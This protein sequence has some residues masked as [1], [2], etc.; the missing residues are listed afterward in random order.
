LIKP[1]DRVFEER[2]QSTTD[3]GSDSLS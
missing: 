3:D 1:E 2:R